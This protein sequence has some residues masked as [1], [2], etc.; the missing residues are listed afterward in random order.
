MVD[1]PIDGPRICIVGTSGSGKTTL[2]KQLAVRLGVP[3][4]CNDE[5]LWLPNWVL[6]DKAE[7][8]RLMCAAT[9][10]PAWTFDGNLG[11]DD[12]DRYVASR[13]TTIVWLDYP[14]HVVMRRIVLRTIRRVALR[15]RLF[16]G[17]VEGF[18]Q[19]FMSG[20]SIICWAN[21]THGKLRVRYSNLF[22]RMNGGR[23]TLVRHCTPWQTERWLRSLPRHTSST[24]C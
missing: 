21:R 13:A 9:A 5:L 15:E 3:Y 1:R 2:A 4:V 20:D 18:R 16:A 8:G 11:S 23:A 6:R 19:S 7:C 12:C 17:N 10:A 22:E 14:K 24:F